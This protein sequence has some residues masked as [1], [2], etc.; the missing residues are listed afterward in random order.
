MVAEE[1]FLIKEEAEVLPHI[2]VFYNDSVAKVEVE[3]DIGIFFALIKVLAFILVIFAV[4]ASL[5][6]VWSENVIA[7]LQRIL[8]AADCFSF[9]NEV[10]VIDK[11]HHVGVG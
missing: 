6:Q 10:A 2:L 9:T 1:K 11:G 7:D 8:K 3:T 5:A 4:K